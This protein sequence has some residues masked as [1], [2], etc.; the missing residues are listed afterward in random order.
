MPADDQQLLHPVTTAGVVFR[1]DREQVLVTQVSDGY[2]VLPGGILELSEHPM[3]GVVRVVSEQTGAVIH[4]FQLTAV[5]K[6]V[7]QGTVCLVF[8][9][10]A[11]RETPLVDDELHRM[12]WLDVDEAR[13]RM[14]D[15][16][17]IM[18]TD[19]L[20][21]FAAPVPVRVHDGVKILR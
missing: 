15:T 18:V 1:N 5:Y 11:R 6:D 3:D 14:S 12:E 13:S 8:R 19:A 7:S 16:Q 2:W 21:A 9:C 10:I 20:A 17:A 4:P